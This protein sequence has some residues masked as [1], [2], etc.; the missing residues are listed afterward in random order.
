MGPEH[1]CKSHTDHQVSLLGSI[2]LVQLVSEGLQLAWEAVP[3]VV[4]TAAPDIALLESSEIKSC[5]DA[6][7]VAASTEGYPE[8]RVLFRV[9]VNY[10]TGS[11][12]YLVIKDLYE[13]KC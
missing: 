6:K 10:L 1:G 12:N 3:K 7:I 8:V 9:R 11:E 2:W 13:N 5:H 4:E